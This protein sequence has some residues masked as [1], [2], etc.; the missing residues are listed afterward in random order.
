MTSPS[1]RERQ[2]MQ[3]LRGAGWV[4]AIVLPDNP[5][6]TQNLIKKGWIETRRDENGV[7]Y[8]I[9]DQGLAAKMAPVRI[10]R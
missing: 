7:Y 3:H 4:K 6:T 8:R 10:Y 5:R 1:H 9:T 2:F